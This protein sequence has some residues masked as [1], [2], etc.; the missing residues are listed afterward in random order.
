MYRYLTRV[1]SRLLVPRS[2]VLGSTGVKLLGSLTLV[3]PGIQ[4]LSYCFQL[5]AVAY[6]Q[7]IS[8]E[9]QLKIIG[10]QELGA[11]EYRCEA[12]GKLNTGTPRHP[13]TV[14]WFSFEGCSLC[15]DI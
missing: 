12:A 1:S 7:I 5:K 15:T 13:T 2:W 3:L 4:Q 10:T 9:G 8:D 6:V 11:G 14:L